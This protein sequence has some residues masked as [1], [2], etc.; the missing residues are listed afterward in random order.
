VT[1]LPQPK[2]LLL[3]PLAESFGPVLFFGGVRVVHQ[4]QVPLHGGGLGPAIGKRGGLDAVL[5]RK[6]AFLLAAVLRAAR[7]YSPLVIQPR[8]EAP[9]NPFALQH[10]KQIPYRPAGP[11]SV[12]VRWR[13]GE[14]FPDS[15]LGAIPGARR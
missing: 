15:Y 4:G 13:A 10:F 11:G 7:R 1:W 9:L 14:D 8:D 6:F 12:V 3:L 5:L 2:H